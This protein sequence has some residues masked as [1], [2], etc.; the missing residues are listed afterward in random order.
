LCS[1]WPKERERERENN[2]LKELNKIKNKIIIIKDQK[3]KSGLEL[4]LRWR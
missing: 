4:L 1:I 3:L 2:M